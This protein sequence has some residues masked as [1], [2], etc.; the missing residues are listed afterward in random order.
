MGLLL[1]NLNCGVIV[2]SKY[3]VVIPSGI[4]HDVIVVVTPCGVRHDGVIVLTPYGVRHV[5]NKYFYGD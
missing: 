5:V 2:I 3:V 4:R 1:V